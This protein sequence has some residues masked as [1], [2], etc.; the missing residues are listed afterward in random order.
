[1]NVYEYQTDCITVEI[2]VCQAQIKQQSGIPSRFY[3]I[4]QLCIECTYKVL[5]AVL[6]NTCIF[7]S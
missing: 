7:L 5:V 4:S 6:F 3:G 2:L 1:M